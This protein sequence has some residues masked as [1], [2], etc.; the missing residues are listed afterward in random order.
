MVSS[1]SNL[2]PPLTFKFYDM[3]LAKFTSFDDSSAHIMM[4]R[5]AHTIQI[6]EP[7]VT[8]IERLRSQ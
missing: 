8:Q 2:P 3:I 6:L 5:S 4:L 7:I 1:E